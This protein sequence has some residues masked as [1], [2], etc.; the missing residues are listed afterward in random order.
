M[1]R[2]TLILIIAVL[3]QAGACSGGGGE[4]IDLSLAD[5]ARFADRYDGELVA[6]R[7]TVQR[8]DDPE[9]YWIEGAQGHRVAIRP[10]E[11][12]RERVGRRVRVVGEFTYDRQRGRSLEPR[13][14]T[15]LD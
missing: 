6:T 8:F 15:L 9:H 5:L 1:R 14:T 11:S 7:G 3:L 2:A 10:P 4:P 13:S 12:V